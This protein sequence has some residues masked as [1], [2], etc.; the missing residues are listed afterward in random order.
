MTPF[1]LANYIL[2]GGV[3][4]LSILWGALVL[5]RL[6]YQALRKDEELANSS[7]ETRR[8]ERGLPA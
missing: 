1:G 5:I 2:I 7:T 3:A 4:A 6:H 8:Q